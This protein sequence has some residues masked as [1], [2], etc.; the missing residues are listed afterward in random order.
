MVS[1]IA[2]RSIEIETI[3]RAS[4]LLVTAWGTAPV[5]YCLCQREE[6][7]LEVGEYFG[8]LRALVRP[9]PGGASL[10]ILAGF[11]GAMFSRENYRQV[12][13]RCYSTGVLERS[14][15]EQIASRL[16]VAVG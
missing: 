2:E 10:E 1:A 13:M 4:G 12:P 7:M 9:A 15:Y 3:D 6:G 11:E 16:G 14:L 8:Q 5:T